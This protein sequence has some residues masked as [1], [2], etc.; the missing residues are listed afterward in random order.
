V[1]LATEPSWVKRQFHFLVHSGAEKD[2]SD[3]AST[4]PPLYKLIVFLFAGVVTDPFLQG[5][6]VFVFAVFKAV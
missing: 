4:N 6:A 1:G 3:E 2:L 5:F